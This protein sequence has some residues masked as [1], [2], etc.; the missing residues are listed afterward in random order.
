MSQRT[1][2][3]VGTLLLHPYQAWDS[4]GGSREGK[5]ERDLGR[6]RK[7][8]PGPGVPQRRCRAGFQVRRS[9]I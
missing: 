3:T 5:A 8:R 2:Q 9:I 7:A 6:G 1:F 4:H